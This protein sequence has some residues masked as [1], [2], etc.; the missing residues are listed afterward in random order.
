MQHITYQKFFL[1]YNEV[2][3]NT[4]PNKKNSFICFL[5]QIILLYEKSNLI[6]V[7]KT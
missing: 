1:L 6:F 3:Y 2:K 4:S 7:S 5:K